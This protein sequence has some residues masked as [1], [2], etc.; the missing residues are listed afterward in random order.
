MKGIKTAAAVIASTFISACFFVGCAKS[1]NVASGD[2][3]RDIDVYP[4]QE[5]AYEKDSKAALDEYYAVVNKHLDESGDIDFEN[6][7]VKTA[8]ANTAA[9]LFAYACYNERTL[10]QYVFFA[11]QEGK[12]DL[13]KTGAATAIKQEYYL[14][15][16]EQE[17]VTCGYRYHYTIKYVKESTGG[18]DFA[19]PFFES[20]RTRITDDT[21]LLYRLE[22]SKISD[23]GQYNEHLG[24]KLLT[25][26][27]ST[28][29][30]WGKP[31]AE[32]KKGGFI[33]PENIRED[34]EQWANDDNHTIHANIN[35]LA[36]NIVKEAVI[37]QEG[38]DCY[39]IV[40]TIDTAVA[41]ADE[42][43]LTML[44]N[45]NS[46]KDCTWID[47][48]DGLRIIFRL[49]NNGLF[50]TY[51]VNEIWQGNISVTSSMSF[52]GSADSTTAYYYSYT[53]RDCD[54]TDNLKF[55][56]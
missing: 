32:M 35:I 11:H 3:M 21:N 16:N 39:F 33:A 48:D 42:A 26:K 20:A 4:T 9:K 41:N 15:V 38:E 51:T 5:A 23:N 50:R 22:G 55:I 18:L 52:S 8:A 27:W 17:D 28:G 45:A 47:D 6:A 49:W 14:R 31:D 25:C 44:R 56:K 10:N 43:S 1:V 13:G 29:K 37:V 40:M 53:D 12:T 34:I 19:K 30:D 36:D 7:E 54:M 46:S 2:I 24:I